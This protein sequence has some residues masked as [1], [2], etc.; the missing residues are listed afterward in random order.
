MEAELERYKA[1]LNAKNE[2]LIA[3]IKEMSAMRGQQIASGMVPVDMD[4][5]VEPKPDHSVEALA[6]VAQ[7]V[8]EL[9]DA[10]QR[11]KRI[12]RGPDGKAQG[13]A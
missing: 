10:M 9:K 11:P 8:A 13:V 3:R 2:L 4:F 7:A 6:M 5:D 12:I 1:D